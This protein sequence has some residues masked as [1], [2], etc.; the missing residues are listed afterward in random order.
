MLDFGLGELGR[1]VLVVRPCRG[2]G[3]VPVAAAMLLVRGLVR[4]T[5]TQTSAGKL[6]A[7][8][9]RANRRRCGIW[10]GGRWAGP[11][12]SRRGIAKLGGRYGAEVWARWNNNAGIW[13]VDFERS[14][15][16]PPS[17][18][19][20][21]RSPGDR[22]LGGVVG[23]LGSHLVDG[24]LRPVVDRHTGDGA[25]GNLPHAGGQPA[26]FN[27]STSASVCADPRC[28]IVRAPRRIEYTIWTAVAPDAVFTVRTYGDTSP[29]FSVQIRALRDSKHAG[30]GPANSLGPDQ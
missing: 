16:G 26:A 14:M 5:I 6:C 15:A 22:G 1:G 12:S 24:P 13:E 18:S 7:R 8:A 19:S 10:P 27:T 21:P 25:T 3:C 11:P 20:R 2:L 30:H 17:R 28:S 9:S 29:E 4:C 23:G